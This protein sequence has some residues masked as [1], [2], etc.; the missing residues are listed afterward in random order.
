VSIE[1]PAERGAMLAQD[2]YSLQLSFLMPGWN[3]KF[4]A[5]SVRSLFKAVARQYAPAHLRLRFFW[6]GMEEMHAFENMYEQWL[7]EKATLQPVQPRLDQLSFDVIQW[8]QTLGGGE[9]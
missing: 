7:A 1:E 4:Q 6:L 8:I 9:A 5:S 2:H 3:A